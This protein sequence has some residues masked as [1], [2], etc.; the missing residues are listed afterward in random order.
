MKAAT[1]ITAPFTVVFDTREQLPFAFAGLTADS[2]QGGGPLEVRT[3]RGTLGQGD[4][5]ILGFETA[6]AV[7]R[8]SI[9]DLFGTL[10]KGRR[11]FTAELERLSSYEF[12]AVVIEGDWRDILGLWPEGLHSLLKWLEGKRLA[13]IGIDPVEAYEV[14]KWAG[15]IATLLN[16]GK[17][18]KS[19]LKPKTIHRSILSWQQR[20]PRIHWEPMPSRRL[21]EITTYRILE[22]FWKEKESQR[23][24]LPCLPLPAPQSQSQLQLSQTQPPA[25]LAPLKRRWPPGPATAAADPPGLPSS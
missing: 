7:E 4:Y 3:Q 20:Y 13:L 1:P 16:N 8:K 18:E 19:R 12:A 22:R 17:P 15:L 10:G 25:P 9:A 5:S 11:R 2:A 24:G 23:R 6:V 14:E 21:A